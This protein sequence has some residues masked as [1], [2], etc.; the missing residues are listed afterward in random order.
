MSSKSRHWHSISYDSA[1]ILLFSKFSRSHI[2]I[3]LHT[4]HK[5]A[6]LCIITYLFPPCIRFRADT[7]QLTVATL[8]RVSA[9]RAISLL[10]FSS[11]QQ[12]RSFISILTAFLSVS[13]CLFVF[14]CAFIHLKVHKIPDYTLLISQHYKLHKNKKFKQ[15]QS[16]HAKTHLIRS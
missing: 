14:I 1:V 12:Q 2:C 8:T 9:F 16:T 11:K 5:Y 7:L 13:L 6:Q 10:L 4:S 3:E 15:V